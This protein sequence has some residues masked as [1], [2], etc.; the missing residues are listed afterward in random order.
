M[1]RRRQTKREEPQQI[2]RIPEVEIRHRFDDPD[3]R[4]KAMLLYARMARWVADHVVPGRRFESVLKAVFL[5]GPNIVWR[6]DLPH[7]YEA[8]NAEFGR[9][10]EVI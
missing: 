3:R 2:M 4:V 9:D 5:D 7:H 10:G 8:F 6:F 1:E